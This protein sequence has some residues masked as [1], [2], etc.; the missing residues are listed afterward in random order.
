[1]ICGKPLY[2]YD[3]LDG[4][5]VLNKPDRVTLLCDL[6]HRERTNGLLP[7]EV[8]EQANRDPINKRLGESAPYT[9]HY[10]GTRCAVEIG[11][12]VIEGDLPEGKT[13]CVFKV[14]GKCLIG[15]ERSDDHLL[16]SLDV[17]GA[18]GRQLILIERNELVYWIN[19]WDIQLV[20]RRLTLRRE[21]GD[22]VFDARFAPPS[23][24]T[25]ERA[26]FFDPAL[27][28]VAHITRGAMT[29]PGNI[30]MSGNTFRNVGTA[31]SYGAASPQR[32]P[33]G[34]NVS[35]DRNRKAGRNELCPCGSGLK[36]KRCHGN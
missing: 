2:E 13:L 36:F 11:S 26:E 16:L 28:S 14:G 1:V 15:F 34:A 7:T 22:I 21:L 29:L 18:D 27:G 9:L 4:P 12:N 6:H 10:A 19:T 8:V 24:V 35:A 5:T 30:I 20:G 32:M 31:I 17:R 23:S 25:I 33:Q 3:H